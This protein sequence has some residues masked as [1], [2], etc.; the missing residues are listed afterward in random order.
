[1]VGAVFKSPLY[2]PTN[3]SQARTRGVLVEVLAMGDLRRERA[4]VDRENHADRERVAS[5]RDV[6]RAGGDFPTGHRGIYVDAWRF[7]RDRK[8]PMTVSSRGD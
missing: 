2:H 3:E 7:S 1:M 8:R 4:A 6:V 5:Y